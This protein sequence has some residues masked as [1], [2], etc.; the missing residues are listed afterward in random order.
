LAGIGN[1]LCIGANVPNSKDGIEQ[2]FH[3]DVKFNNINGKLRIHTLQDIGQLKRGRSVFRIYLE[4]NRVCINKAQL[5]EEDGVTLGWTWKAHP[6]F[7]Y[8]YDMKETLC[9][10][11]GEKFNRVQYVFFP[12]QSSTKGARKAKTTNEHGW[13]I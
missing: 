7:C 10:M 11:M 6:D 12:K 4:N 1:N 8:R 13:D 5:G 3:H 2:Y 9:S